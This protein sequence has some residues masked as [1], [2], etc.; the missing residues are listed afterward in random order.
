[1]TPIG[2]NIRFI[3]KPFRR[4]EKTHYLINFYLFYNLKIKVKTSNES[5]EK[6][7]IKIY[8]ICRGASIKHDFK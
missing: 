5:D 8:T 2:D 1:M 6:G 3:L 7:L 4:N